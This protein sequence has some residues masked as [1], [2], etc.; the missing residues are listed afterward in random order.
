[1]AC[2]SSGTCAT[3]SALI[4]DGPAGLSAPISCPLIESVPDEGGRIPDNISSNSDCPFPDTPAMPSISPERREKLRPSSFV[5]PDCVSEILSAFRHI[6]VGVG[7]LYPTSSN[8]GLP[9]INSASWRGEV[10]CVARWATISPPRITDTASVMAIISFSLWV[11]SKIVTPCARKA[12]RIS[13][14]CSVS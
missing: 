3:P 9:T 7:G 14:S 4:S 1:M 13:N 6:S 5:V 11:M 2:L 10:S 12:F 8:T